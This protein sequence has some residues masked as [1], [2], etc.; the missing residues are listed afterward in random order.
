MSEIP[1]AMLRKRRGLGRKHLEGDGVEIGALHHPMELGRR[2]RVRY[3]DRMDVDGLRAHYPE[4]LDHA[5]V[6][7]DV[8]DDGETLGT[9]AD[10]SL[11]FVVANHFLEHTE[12]PLGTI[13]N[14]LGKVRVGGAVYLAIPD[15]DYS[16]DRRRAL[17]PFDH[18]V[19]DDV[20]GPSW[21][22]MEHFREW[23]RH[24]EGVED[25]AAVEERASRLEA[26]DYSI[27]FHVWDAGSFA[28]FINRAGEHLGGLFEV[29][30]F[31]R[32][33]NEVVVVL[34]RTATP[35]RSRRLDPVALGRPTPAAR[36]RSWKAGLKAALGRRPA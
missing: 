30:E 23:T 35:S 27:H 14:H 10:G 25:P 9:L 29:R 19:R 17:T 1:A 6:P 22:R 21:S 15:R 7:V 36:L 26:M 16:F 20:E 34:G 8:V 11:D 18:L 13:R 32:N 12:N 3:L 4:L 33:G 31:T 5:L 2:A 28:D 24:V